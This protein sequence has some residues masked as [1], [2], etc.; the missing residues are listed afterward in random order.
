[1]VAAGLGGGCI[2]AFGNRAVGMRDSSPAVLVATTGAA[3][4]GA[5]RL[6]AKGLSSSGSTRVPS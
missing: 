3:G 5:G 6:G 2:R 1:M 4:L